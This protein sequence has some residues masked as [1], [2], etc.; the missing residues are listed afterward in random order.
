MTI[1]EALVQ[2]RKLLAANNIEDASL[3]SEL[4][5]RQALGIS[6]VQLYLDFDCELTPE[7]EAAFQQLVQRRLRHE[8][9]AYITGHCEFYGL[10]FYV[11][12]RALIPRPGTEL[13]VEEALKVAR[14]HL[15]RNKRTYLI[16]DVGAGSGNVGITLAR[17]LPRARIYAS[18]I[19][20]AA[21]EVAAMNCQRHRVEKQI[22]LLLGDLLM[23]MPEPVDLIVANLPY[24]SQSEMRE[25]SPEIQLFEPKIALDGG[26]D[27]LGKI[28]Q[29]CLQLD[30]KLRR[31]GTLLLE[32][33]LGQGNAVTSFLG[34][35][36]PAAAMKLVPD[37]NGVDRVARLT[38]TPSSPGFAVKRTLRHLVPTRADSR[39][40]SASRN[41]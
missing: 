19:S 16:A 14:R 30:G 29:L 27:G 35:L 41:L 1:R 38:L 22:E 12:P 3:E 17:Y 21:L 32:I 23:P 37:W 36:Y 10:D 25:L 40:S 24:I 11:D 31:C 28:R 4:L 5:L 34:R 15:S 9:T 18:D 33:G 20:A 26:S 6:R 13:L 2:A 39:P 7:Q 8:P